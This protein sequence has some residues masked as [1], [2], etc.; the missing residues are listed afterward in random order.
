MSIAINKRYLKKKGIWKIRFAASI[1]LFSKRVFLGYFD[2]RAKALLAYNKAKKEAGNKFRK[3]GQQF[4]LTEI[5]RGINDGMSNADAAKKF[6]CSVQTISRARKIVGK[7]IRTK[8]IP[9]KRARLVA[10]YPNYT[11]KELA[12]KLNVSLRT[13]Y[14]EI[15][16][17]GLNK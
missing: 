6:D 5:G 9:S 3:S 15:K 2:S 12:S 10:L 16:K 4:V 17:L 13:I 14:K 8:M 7:N 1:P 11:N